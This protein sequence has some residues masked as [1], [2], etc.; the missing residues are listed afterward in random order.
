MIWNGKVYKI[1]RKSFTGVDYSVCKK[2][3]LTTDPDLIAD[4]VQGI[5]NE[6][7]RWFIKN[8]TCEFVEVKELL[9]NNGNAFYGYKIIIPQEES[10]QDYKPNS[11]DIIF[12]T[13]A[14]IEN[15]QET[16]EE[17]VEK[18]AKVKSSSSV[19]KEAHKKDFI[20][21]AN[22]QAK[23][24]YSEEEMY[25]TLQKLRLVFKSGVQK[26]QEDFEFDLDKWFE[27]FKKR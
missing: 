16:L 6:F 1:S 7:L 8:P 11:C 18:Y 17:A 26:W 24:M 4:G 12:E 5:D 2:I 3:I 15:K 19:F 9:S 21:G 14:L 22:W 27:Q 10:K 20:E 25:S 13:A 23:K